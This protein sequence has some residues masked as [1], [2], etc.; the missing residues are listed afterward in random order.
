VRPRIP[1]TPFR[2]ALKEDLIIGGSK[3]MER[4]RE[5]FSQMSPEKRKHKLPV[6]H[7]RHATTVQ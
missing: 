1:E 3:A 6:S 5:H 7:L 2:T 4:M